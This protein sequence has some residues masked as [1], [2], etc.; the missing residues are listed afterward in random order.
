MHQHV[1]PQHTFFLRTHPQHRRS[2]LLIKEIGLE[3]H[4]HAFPDFECMRQHHVLRFGIHMR[5]LKLRRDP[6]P[7]DLHP[8]V[9]VIDVSE[10]RAADHA[11]R[12]TVDRN[13]RQRCTRSSLRESCIHITL[14]RI[15]RVSPRLRP[16]PQLRETARFAQC[17]EMTRPHRLEPHTLSL[18][19]HRHC[20]H[21]EPYFAGVSGIAG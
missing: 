19:R 20:V 15:G 17:V 7:A 3:L 18:E 11:P 12:F 8:V 21:R 14:H 13:E 5:A 6:G 10:P 4:P 1:L 2:R 16:F 9:L